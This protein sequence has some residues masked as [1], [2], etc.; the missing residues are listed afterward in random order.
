MAEQ[1]PGEFVKTFANDVL[2]LLAENGITGHQAVEIAAKIVASHMR[3]HHPEV[4]EAALAQLPAPCGE[5]AFCKAREDE[6]EDLTVFI[7]PI[8]LN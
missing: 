1:S 5:C 4:F 7:V 6:S 3:D 2:D 8:S